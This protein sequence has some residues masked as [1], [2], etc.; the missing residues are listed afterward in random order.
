MVLSLW[1]FSLSMKGITVEASEFNFSV[2]AVITENQID[3]N[4]TYFDLMMEPSQQQTIEVKLGNDTEEE[5]TIS[6]GVNSATTNIN[7]VVEYGKNDIPLDE[8]L[9]YDIADII[10]AEKEVTIPAN[11]K[12]I[13]KLNVTM[14]DEKF[15]GV[16]AGGIT[17]QEVTRETERNSDTATISI[18]N[19]YAYVVAVLLRGGTNKI[20]P[21]LELNDIFPAQVNARNVIN[22]NIQNTE[23]MYMNQMGIEAKITRKGETETLYG[24]NSQNLQMA[25]NSN[26][27]YPI[28]LNGEK[29]EGGEYTLELTA[30][31]MGEV[32]TWTR[33]FTIDNAEADEL[34]ATDVS[35]TN[36]YSWLI[37]VA[38]IL[39]ALLT[40]ILLIVL[41]KKRKE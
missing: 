8:T 29:M 37:Y 28:S 11:S 4:Q 19:E 18:E 27:D 9:L 7:G 14:P 30:T 2:H 23:A 40:I 3:K 26:F 32:W 41:K 38:I 12:Y 1:I 24:S 25:P 36:N 22:A 21:N 34:N 31:S 13:L 20:T 15:D 5:V 33:D 39:V 17:F 10:S 6:V 35:I 16:I